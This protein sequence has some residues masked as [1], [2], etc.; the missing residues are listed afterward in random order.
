MTEKPGKEFSWIE[1]MAFML[2]AVAIQLTSEATSQWGVYF[3]SPAD[4]GRRII[5]ISIGVVWI[6]F[7]TGRLFDAITDP[8]IGAWSDKTNPRSEERRVGKECRSRW[9]AYH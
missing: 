4:T 6:V 2:A 7:V 9:S 1:G 5:Y 8:L 3:Y